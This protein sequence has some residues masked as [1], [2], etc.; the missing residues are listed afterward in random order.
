M[1]TV[2]TRCTKHLKAQARGILGT[3]AT[4]RNFTRSWSTAT[5]RVGGAMRR[6]TSRRVSKQ[7]VAAIL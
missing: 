3:E 6:T 7:D 2:R 5:A 4:G 1:A